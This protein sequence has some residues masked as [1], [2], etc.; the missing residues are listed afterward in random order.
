MWL[1]RKPSADV[2]RAFLA[3]VGDA[4][5]SYDE[6]GA[7]RGDAR[8]PPRGYQFDH[9][10][11]R[12]GQGRAAFDAACE[13]L[14]RWEMFQLGWVEPGDPAAPLTPHTSVAVL[15]RAFGLWSLN[16]CRIVYAID[17]ATPIRTFGFAYGT[18]PDHAERGEER[19]TIEWREDDGV[20]YDLRAFSRPNR[21]YTWVGYP[22]VR[23]LQ[24]RFAA[25]SL[26]AMAR[27]VAKS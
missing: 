23:R 27:A 11:R 9:N 14:R 5:F 4:P 17:Q 15:A 20:W 6:V 21:W 25:D 19:F 16:A 8:R 26:D 22:I 2:I 24:K 12:L 1:R 7:S 3:R 13:A 18:L 10:R